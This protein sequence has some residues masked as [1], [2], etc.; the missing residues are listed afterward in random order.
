MSAD[1]T[2]KELK[3]EAQWGN[4]FA[5]HVLGTLNR[6]AKR[7]AKRDHRPYRKECTK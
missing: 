2:I 1:I 3:Q 6:Q 4:L 5:L 7:G